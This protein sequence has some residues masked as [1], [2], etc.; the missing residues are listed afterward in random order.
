[1][2]KIIII[3]LAVMLLADLGIIHL[4]IE[5]LKDRA[6]D[7][8]KQLQIVLKI[9]KRLAEICNQQHRA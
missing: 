3:L 9:A 2:T 1:M 7:T 5:L 4:E 8:D 6:D